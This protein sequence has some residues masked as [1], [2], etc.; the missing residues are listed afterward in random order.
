MLFQPRDFS[1]FANRAKVSESKMVYTRYETWKKDTCIMVPKYFSRVTLR[2]ERTKFVYSNYELWGNHNDELFV[3]HMAIKDS[4]SASQVLQDSG[5]ICLINGIDLESFRNQMDEI[6]KANPTLI[7]LS[8]VWNRHGEKLENRNYK[9]LLKRAMKDMKGK[10]PLEE[11]QKL[12]KELDDL[13]DELV[14]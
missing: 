7:L 12:R 4:I 10:D 14:L 1:D 13:E 5:L 8:A 2:N 3:E 11:Y 6:E 9:S